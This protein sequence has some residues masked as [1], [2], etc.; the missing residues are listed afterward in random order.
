M[1]K[2]K[3]FII[4]VFFA[5]LIIPMIFINLKDDFISEIDNSVLP[6]LNSV[7]NKDSLENYLQKRIGFREN[8]INIYTIVNDRLFNKMVHPIYDYGKDGYVYFKFSNEEFD[9]NY[10]DSYFI[11]VKRLQ[12][13]IYLQVLHAQ[14]DRH[15]I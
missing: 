4:V 11:F 7:D 1:K 8:V 2:Y 5:I 13:Y 10:L 12:D 9:I 3:L 6:K 15:L 14:M